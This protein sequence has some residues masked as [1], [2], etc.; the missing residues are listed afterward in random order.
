MTQGVNLILIITKAR[1]EQAHLLST[2]IKKWLQERGVTV[3]IQ[4][5]QEHENIVPL[6]IPNP[7]MILVLGG[8]GT[9]I[10]VARKLGDTPIPLLGLNMG[11][12]G[13]LTELTPGNW[14]Q[15][16]LNILN[17]QYQFSPRIA[18]E[19][20]VRRNA[21]I[22]DSGRVVNDLV[23][24]RGGMARLIHLHLD[25][26]GESL[27]KLRADGLILATPTGSTAYGVSAGGP[28]VF[29]ELELYNIIPICPFMTGLR[30]LVLPSKQPFSVLIEPGPEAVYLTLDGQCGYT[31]EVGDRVEIRQAP[32]KLYFVQPK[33]SSYINKLKANAYIKE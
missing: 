16:L 18:L 4:E 10:S 12:I 32:T 31:L 24:N 15:R 13:F 3:E 20:T 11:R 1:N 6:C 30:P 28:L 23:I 7:D 27:G 26:A 21:Q 2:D 25:F 5:N 33:S 9:M 29:P 14:Q 8:D 19:Y 22:I 17:Q